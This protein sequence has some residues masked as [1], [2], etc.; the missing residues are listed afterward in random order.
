V[1]LCD[2]KISIFREH[3][4]IEFFREEA[5]LQRAENYKCEIQAL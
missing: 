3:C 5:M 4:K 1:R 2:D